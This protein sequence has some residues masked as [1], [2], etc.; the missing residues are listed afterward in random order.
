MRAVHP[1]DDDR[2][3]MQA[4]KAL[5][6]RHDGLNL[7]T[8]RRRRRR[9]RS[10]RRRER[11]WRAWRRAWSDASR[12][13]LS[14]RET[15]CVS[16]RTPPRSIRSPSSDKNG[17]TISARLPRRSGTLAPGSRR[18]GRRCASSDQVVPRRRLASARRAHRAGLRLAGSIGCTVSE[19]SSAEQVD[20]RTIH[21]GGNPLLA[22][23]GRGAVEP[24]DDVP[25][26]IG[27]EIATCAQKPVRELVSRLGTRETTPSGGT[28]LCE[29]SRG[30]SSVRGTRRDQSECPS[31]AHRLARRHRRGRL[32]GGSRRAH[33]ECPVCAE[34]RCDAN[35]SGT[36][37]ALA[38]S[39][40]K[41]VP[42]ACD[43]SN[44]VGG[45]SCSV[46]AARDWG[47]SIDGL[48]ARA[49]DRRECR[50]GCRAPA[51]TGTRVLRSRSFRPRSRSGRDCRAAPARPCA[52]VRV[53]P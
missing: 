26:A 21:G 12:S 19:G 17:E 49:R 15:R 14:A 28:G 27:G 7:A 30:G 22:L 48:Q 53:V 31:R 9:S 51:A 39:S 36:A 1:V 11:T 3:G 52:A 41:V 35:D 34:S 23:A 5:P 33:R 46:S 16:V 8:G 20:E 50:A 6:G 38:R 44:P 45:L 2:L 47:S 4:R 37:N 25:A 40:V 18:H 13:R 29:R 10:T 42:T 24:N 43:S 32:R